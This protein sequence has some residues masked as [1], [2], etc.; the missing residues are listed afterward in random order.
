MLLAIDVGNT[1]ITAGLFQ[2]QKLA[3]HWRLSSNRDR[4]EDETWT[5]MQAICQANGFG[6]E[7]TTGIIISS[8]VPDMTSSLHKMA[9]K[10][11]N[12]EPVIVSHDLDLGI[13]N[14]Y[15]NPAN[16]GADRL[17]NAIAGFQ[18]Y[19]G[20]LIIVDLGTATTFDVIDAKGDYL[21]GIIAP[22]IET[23][24]MTLHQR[25]AK[26]P[27]IELRFPDQV[28]G[29]STES[30]M[31]SGLLFGAVELIDGLMERINQEM[32]QEVKPVATGGLGRVIIHELRRVSEYDAFLTL[33]GM[34]M[35]YER[36]KK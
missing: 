1:Q 5:L 8:V 24:A 21:G 30:S 22:G 25:A 35:I 11:L 34:R 15:R 32:G 7:Q 27:R 20:P 33:D 18:K 31:Q 6:M 28:I 10:Y 9:T 26:L 14:Y 17:C 36:V 16:V 2:K 3:A 29:R 23:S 4:T 13:H 19:G 12:L